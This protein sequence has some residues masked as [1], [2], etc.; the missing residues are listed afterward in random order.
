MIQQFKQITCGLVTIL[1]MFV[2]TGCQQYG[3]VSPNAYEIA[4]SLYAAC[5]Q[6]DESRLAKLDV[7][8]SD[9]LKMTEITESEAQWL[10][11]IV[12]TARSGDWTVAMQNA[13]TMLAEQIR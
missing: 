4:R 1:L 7:L 10:S 3:E 13:R 5:N 8:I 12:E 2:I 9:N 6:K 11:T